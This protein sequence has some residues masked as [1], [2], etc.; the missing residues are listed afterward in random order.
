MLINQMSATHSAVSA[1]SSRFCCA[2]TSPE[3]RE[4]YERSLT[5]L[6]RTFL[7]QVEGLKKHRATAQ[8]TVRVERV[9]VNEGGQAVVG[10]ISNRRGED[11]EK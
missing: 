7:A 4:S 9:E 5:R 3:L 10:D 6:N 11:D 8:Q 1:M 2:P